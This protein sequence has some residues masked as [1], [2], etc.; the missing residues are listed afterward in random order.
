MDFRHH[1]HFESLFDENHIPLVEL[2]G[3]FLH[4][5]IEHWI[6][7]GEQLLIAIT[8]KIVLNSISTC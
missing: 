6:S 7:V 4:Y 1:D 5:S 8:R 3:R 2:L